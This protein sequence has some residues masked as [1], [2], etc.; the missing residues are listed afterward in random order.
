MKKI[1]IGY[2]ADGPWSH[3]TFKKLINDNTIEIK[4]IVVRIG[5]KDQ[6]LK[7]YASKYNIDYFSNVK[8]NS[9]EFLSLV[10]ELDLDLL[11]SMSFNQIFRQP[12]LNIPKLGIINC[13]SGKLPY[14]RGRNILNW[15]LINDE[16]E[17]GITVHYVNEGIDTG[18]IIKQKCFPINDL[19]DYDSLLN[20]AYVECAEILY[21][22]IKEMQEG[23]SKRIPQK[24]IHPFGFYCS[25]REGGD[26]IIDWNSNSRQIFN[27]IRAITYPGPL[28]KTTFLG[29]DV[30][31]IKSK[32]ISDAPK[33]IDTPGKILNKT[34][35]GFIIKTKDSFIEILEIKTDVKLKV[36]D[37]LGT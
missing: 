21:S 9:S 7:N 31:I 6:T 24:L 18:D 33:Y 3:A 27:F 22:S 11:V 10:V 20:I 35:N 29:K 17:F 37:K 32:Y 19:D 16:K 8:V 14:Y 25:K 4:F 28:A 12:L 26:E 5:S 23:V 2:L 1:S 13:H 15:A 34:P 36:G 30:K